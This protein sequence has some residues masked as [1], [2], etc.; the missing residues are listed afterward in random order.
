MFDEYRLLNVK[1]LELQTRILFMEF[2][3]FSLYNSETELYWNKYKRRKGRKSSKLSHLRYKN[4]KYR[5][6]C[7]LITKSFLS[8]SESNIQLSNTPS[9]ESF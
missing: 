6:I 5:S 1:I 4:I 2:P 8:N 9:S 7:G 3:I